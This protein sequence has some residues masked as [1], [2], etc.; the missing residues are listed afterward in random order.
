MIKNWL[1]IYLYHIRENKLF[2]F[3]NVFGLSIGI[4]GLI[5][6]MLYWNDEQ[7]YNAA[8]PG[9][10]TIFFTVSDLGE[11]KVWGSSSDAL[12]TVL[13][14]LQE[15][16]SYCYMSGWYDSNI[17]QAGGKKV[18]A[19]KVV[20]AQATFFDFFPFRFIK[21]NGKTA[22]TPSSIAISEKLATELFGSTAV[23]GRMVTYNEK[24]YSIGGVY[25]LE[26]KS[27]YMP[28]MVLS[29][30]DAKLRE[31]AA[32]WGNFRFALFLNLRN[33]EDAQKVER[34]IEALYLEND[35]KKQ[36]QS[37]GLSLEDYVKRSGTTRVHLEQLKDIR[38]HTLAGDVPE[39][40]GNYQLLLIMMGLSVLILIMSVVNYVNLATANA[41]KRAKEVGVRKVLG[42]SR[43]DVVAQFV[44]ESMVACFFAMLLALVVVEVS[45]PYYNEFL[46][47]D[48]TLSNSSFF[49]QL[50]VIFVVVVLTAGFF[51]AL[52]VS[53]Y[54]E[55]QVLRGTIGSSRKGVLLRNTM[56][57]VQFAIASFFIIGS[58][59]VYSQVNHLVTKD[60]GF[61]ADQV[62]SVYYRNP[63]DFKV[64]GFKKII[65]GKYEH[66]KEQVR[67]LNGVEA[68]A[69]NTAGVGE[70]SNFFTGY[71]YNGRFYSMQNMVGDFGLTEMLQIKIKEGRPLSAR[72]AEDT[73]SSVLLNE[74]AVKFLGIKNPVG[75][76]L[77]WEE[78]R[79]LR[80]VGITED[81][82]ING[83]HQK[84][85]PVIL[86]HYKT[87]DWMLQNAH[88]IYVKLDP[89]KRE[90]AL[91]AIEKLWR[92]EVD[93]DYPFNYYFINKEF[94]NTYKSYVQQRN[95]FTLLN[96]VVIVIALFGL[97]ALASFNIQRRMKEIAIRKTLGAETGT[98]LIQLTIQYIFLGITGFAVAVV[99]A[100]SLLSL[101]LD[102]FAYRIE[103][104][105][106]PFV[107]S[108][109][110]LMLLTLIVVL[111]KT[112]AATK[113]EVLK[114]LKYE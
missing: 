2:T 11:D 112:Y 96:I 50:A 7:S 16:K 30:I 76:T 105:W 73:I 94:E 10:S 110:A 53:A 21:G 85:M 60:P 65:A 19:E 44:F 15:V 41:I 99:P 31:N 20:D 78:G 61:R 5:F 108:F 54:K 83:P 77:D 56:L 101:W 74:S 26:G 34:K 67:A 95:L 9:K 18:M 3:L 98:L 107:L 46:R 89:E 111:C 84:I 72:F 17:L 80:I 29:T 8:N 55:V 37:A 57:A 97:F 69:A 12:V 13:P 64:P 93:P 100:W 22:L 43:R 32:N 36:A 39:G 106:L 82:H 38:L 114:Y 79:Q 33:P 63:Y 52:Y 6:G 92:E 23:M 113:T 103:L 24:P 90:E 66:I 27:S 45:L 91:A 87:V 102:N 86:Y 62:V 42:A 35:T 58:Y 109:V 40:K 49:V 28:D 25:K 81:F 59:V 68:V 1:K 71:G 4:A 70:G 48:L 88:H 47:K 14:T 51:P 75:A 104:S